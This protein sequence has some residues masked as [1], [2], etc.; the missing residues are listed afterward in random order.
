MRIAYLDCFSGIAGDM[1]IASMIHAGAPL[2]AFQD[3]VAKLDLPGVALRATSVQRH[4]IA[5]THVDVAVPPEARK[6]HRHLPQI[7]E[8]IERAK[9]S[10]AAT[11]RAIAIFRALAEAEAT[12]HG[13]TI[14][15][16]H[17]HEVGAADAIVDICCAAVGIELLEVDELHC[18]AIPPGSGT[19]TCEHGVMPVPAPATAQL[20]RDLPIAGCDEQAE[21]ATPTGVAIARTLATRFGP[22]PDMTVRAAG[23]GAGTREGVTRPNFM[24]ILVGDAAVSAAKEA[25]HVTLLEAQVDD[26]SGQALAYATERLFE[27]GALDVFI[28]PI[29]MKKGRPGH[30]LTV[31]CRD[32]DQTTL[33]DVV[34]RHTSTFGV[35]AT[36]CA[37]QILDRESHTVETPYGQVRVKVGR[38]AGRLVQAWPEYD[39]CESAARAS[40]QPLTVV[41]DAALSAWR[42]SN[43]G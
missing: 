23:Y 24:R 8:I 21:L 16:V 9:L 17:F 20:L 12:V 38:R 41:Q 18:S 14:E 13:T 31:L 22:A 28:V 5:C 34:F 25:D 36:R 33:Q 2:A 37:R 35:R 30:L 10:A 15:K 40:G 26:L 4:G 29:M 3:V 32:A 19:V 42:R 6:K 43:S 1:T 39:D 7:V 27:A 11:G